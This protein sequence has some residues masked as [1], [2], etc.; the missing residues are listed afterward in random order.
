MNP[1]RLDPNAIVATAENLSLRIDERFE[2]RGISEIGHHLLGTARATRERLEELH[3]PRRGLRYGI[4]ALIL[5]TMAVATYA[6]FSVD[7][8]VDE[9]GG[10]DDWIMVLEA[11]LQDLVFVGL[12]VVFVRGAEAR[13]VRKDALI[14]LHQLRSVAHVIDM[15]QLT[16]D[17]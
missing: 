15:H 7:L 4:A 12:A 17:P 1:S 11:G 14:G 13:V 16:K 6:A 3:R 9:V 5:V 2:G 10:I 8:D